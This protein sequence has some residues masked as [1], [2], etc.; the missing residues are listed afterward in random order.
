VRAEIE[1]RSG[2]DL[3]RVEQMLK[4]LIDAKTDRE[5][6]MQA[7][8]LLANI[9]LTRKEFDKAVSLLEEGAD[10]GELNVPA[11]QTLA[12]AYTALNQRDKAQRYLDLQAENL[13]RRDVIYELYE[14]IRKNPSDPDARYQMGRHFYDGGDKKGALTWWYTAVLA[15][16]LHQDSHEALAEHYTAVGELKRAREHLALAEQSVE[17]TFKLAWD[18]YTS[19]DLPA[20]ER[21]IP[22]IIKY[23]AYKPHAELLEFALELN[24]KQRQLDPA[25]LEA[26]RPLL[27]YPRLHNKALTL[28]GAGMFLL[29]RFG[30]AEQA[31]LEVV[32]SEPESI[33]AHRWLAAMNKDIRALDRMY[34][35]CEQWARLDPDDYR[36]HRLM[37]LES[38]TRQA[39][40]DAIYAYKESLRR[41]PNQKT[42]E[43]V[44]L[45]LAE[46]EYR[47]GLLDDA[48]KTLDKAADSLQRD[49]LRAECLLAARRKDEA[50]QLLAEI[51]QSEPKEMIANMLRAD[52]AAQEGDFQL[53]AE[54]LE[55][56]TAEYPSNHSLWF[57]LSQVYKKMN[58]A[59]KARE[60]SEQAEYLR[61]IETRFFELMEKAIQ[62][63]KDIGIRREL[64]ALSRQLS[65]PDL[66]VEWDRAAEL[67]ASQQN[68][69][70]QTGTKS[71]P[72]V[73][74]A[75]G[76][77]SLPP[78]I[79]PEGASDP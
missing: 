44:L 79:V 33:E 19:D 57:K 30:E 14:R 54:H 71:K 46:C 3:S 61:S 65:R 41:D 21:R 42:R 60:T 50:K 8:T 74:P 29:G 10:R 53:A 18:E 24:I 73:P 2:G 32:V 45:E 43:E 67:L 62:L 59:D 56:V 6:R 27:D 25:H 58:L 52:I 20:V 55:T 11:Y 16:P 31:L 15:E 9:Y 47:S 75:D 63:P 37:G 34:Y 38:K 13:K 78:L 7:N 76:R 36:P 39:F 1:F 66:A 70:A 72:D 35:H 40:A 26:L 17:R 22:A 5:V 28:L 23:P 77:R 51:L 48:L 64:A 12:R 68:L 49:V 4:T 69:E